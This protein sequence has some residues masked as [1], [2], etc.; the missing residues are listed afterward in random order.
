MAPQTTDSTQIPAELKPADGRF[1][2]GPSKVR[3]E[4]LAALA[5]RSDLMGTSHRQA[6]VARPGRPRARRPRRALLAARRLRGRARQRRHHRLLGRRRRLAR[7]RARPAPHLRRVLAEVRQGDRRRRRSSPTRSWSRP[8]R[9]TRPAPTADPAADVIAWAHNET[10]TGVM[11]AGRAPRRRRRR[12]GPDRRHL[13]RRRPAASTS[14][15]PTPTT[16]PRRRPSAPTA[17]SGWRLLSPAAIARIE[18]LDGAAGRWQPGFLSLQTALD[19]SRKEQTYNTPALATL[20]LLADQVEWMLANGGLDWC[21]ERTSDSS[22]RLYGWAEAQ[23]RRHALRRRPGQALAGRRHDRLRR[24]GR[25]RGARRGAARQRH[26]RRRALPQARPQPAAGRDV[27]GGRARRRRGADR[28]HRLGPRERRGGRRVKVLVKEKIADTGVDLLRANFDVD[29]GLEMADEELRERIGDYDA[30]LIR[31][32]TKM[33][34]ELIELRDQPQG[35]RPRRHRRRQRRHPGR[36][37][38]RD[39]RRQRARVELGRRRRAHAGAG[40]GALPQRP[41]GARHRWS[42]AAGTGPSSRAPSSTARRSG[43]VG[44]G[45]IGQLVAKRAQSFEMEVVAFDKFVS[46]ERFRELGVEG[47]EQRRGGARARR[48]RHRCTC[49]RRRRRSA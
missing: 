13:G 21:V 39:H 28:L 27:P 33:T 40:A 36:D 34:P 6:P 49:R 46:A 9:A 7:A 14:A 43:V 31:S 2:C 30:I 22:G 37:P 17:A 35:D 23:R 48:P 25:R 18:E 10:S 32:A 4:A 16:S 24:L 47:V 29:L 12:P 3:P 41:A 11:V 15:R 8:S 42:P 19:N 26:R 44:F 45:R 38:P 1:G 5:E 20:L